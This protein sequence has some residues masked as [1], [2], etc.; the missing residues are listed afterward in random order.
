M[1]ETKRS[2]VGEKLLYTVGIA[3]IYLIGRKLP[4]YGVDYSVYVDRTIDA[5]VIFQQAIN[6]D[7]TQ[8]S[9]FSLGFSPYIAASMLKQFLFAGQRNKKKAKTSPRKANDVMLF[10]MM[11]IAMIQVVLRVHGLAYQADGQELIWTKMICAVE[12]I[13]GMLILVWLSDRNQKYGIG[14]RSALIFVNIID[15]LLVALGTVENS[16]ELVVPLLISLV[17]LMIFLFMENT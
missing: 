1:K 10:C 13:V 5:Q 9:I 16:R 2:V 6:G 12:M 8:T 11:L 14:G 4:L 7:L 17:V 15:G 3:L